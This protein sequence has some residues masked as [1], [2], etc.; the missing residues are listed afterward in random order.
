MKQKTEKFIDFYF[1]AKPEKIP[2][3]REYCREHGID[4]PELYVNLMEGALAD[5]NT[6][7][8]DNDILDNQKE[9]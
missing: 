2:I 9:E 7:I 8:D 4:E 3:V 5:F 6:F 1:T